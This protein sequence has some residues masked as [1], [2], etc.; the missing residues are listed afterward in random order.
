MHTM[1]AAPT[2]Q[3][4]S[5]QLHSLSPSERQEVV[6]EALRQSTPDERKAVERL[7]R[8]LQHPDVPEDVWEGFE[9]CE[10]GKAIEM[11]DEHFARP[12]V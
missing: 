6:A 4:I 8:R 1:N 3:Q 7:L 12:P 9:E 10:D 5:A 11:R 2:V